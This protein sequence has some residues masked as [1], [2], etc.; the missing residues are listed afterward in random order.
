MSL[1]LPTKDLSHIVCL[2]IGNFIGVMLV[3]ERRTVLN[4]NKMNLLKS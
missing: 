3:N 1:R 4:L 2:R